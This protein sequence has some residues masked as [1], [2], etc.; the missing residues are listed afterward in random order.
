[1][2]T[3]EMLSHRDGQRLTHLRRVRPA[4]ADGAIPIGGCK[5]P[6]AGPTCSSALFFG[7]SHIVLAEM[8]STV[9][10]VSTCVSPNWSRMPQPSGFVDLRPARR[11]GFVTPPRG[12]PPKCPRQTLT[13]EPPLYR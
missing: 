6:Y 2:E 7:R 9:L 1:M 4:A 8:L 13:A 12:P 11:C 3:G 5:G 10:M